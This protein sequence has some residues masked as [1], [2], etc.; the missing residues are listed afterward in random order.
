MCKHKRPRIAKRIIDNK[1]K[2]GSITILNFKLY[3]RPTVI[4]K[5]QRDTVTRNIE[6]E[7]VEQKRGCKNNPKHI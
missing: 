6:I 5:K 4:L 1:S 3:H 7:S 2:I